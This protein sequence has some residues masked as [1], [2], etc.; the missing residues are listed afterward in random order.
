MH[1]DLSDLGVPVVEEFH[2]LVDCLM[3]VTQQSNYQEK[4]LTSSSSVGM[5]GGCSGGGGGGGGEKRVN[6]RSTL[7]FFPLKHVISSSSLRASLSFPLPFYFLIFPT[8]LL[9]CTYYQPTYLT[10]VG[11][12]Y[13]LHLLLYT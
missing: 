7:Y 6:R 11:I 2:Q 4:E 1:T 12:L 3:L 5:V 8:P 13:P 10:E 9:L